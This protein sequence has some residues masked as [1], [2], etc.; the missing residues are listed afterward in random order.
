MPEQCRGEVHFFGDDHEKLVEFID[1]F[2]FPKRKP[3]ETLVAFKDRVT[4][5]VQRSSRTTVGR[6]ITA[7]KW[8]G[9]LGYH[10]GYVEV[11]LSNALKV[12]QLPSF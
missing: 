7:V 2:D 5:L 12:S 3:D 1:S 8:I 6:K 4:S 11:P 10:H 9:P